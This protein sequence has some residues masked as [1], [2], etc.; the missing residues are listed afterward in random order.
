VLEWQFNL[1]IAPD[2]AG[3]APGVIQPAVPGNWQWRGRRNLIF[4]PQ[5]DLPKAT[6]FTVT[7]PADR[8]RT[9][10]GFRLSGPFVANIGTAPLRV[11]GVRQGGF[12]D[13][14][15]YILEIEFDDAV[16]PADVVSKLSLKGPDDKPL[17]F[18]LHG[19]GIGKIVR[20]MTDSI[21]ATDPSAGQTVNVV[22]RLDRG[23]AGGAGPLGLDQPYEQKLSLGSTLTATSVT[24]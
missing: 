4:Q 16:I 11:L 8:L 24:A 14:R 17:G 2:A 19:E 21:G 7:I 13:D 6:P 1:D 10:E 15:R 9:P 20:V 22:V 23:L 18:T 12:A 3:G 5:Q